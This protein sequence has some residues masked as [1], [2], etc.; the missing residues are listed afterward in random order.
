[1]TV[2]PVG[3]RHSVLVAGFSAYCPLR[4]DQPDRGEGAVGCWWSWVSWSSGI[5]L[6]WRFSRRVCR[7]LELPPVCRTPDL[8]W[9]LATGKDVRHARTFPPGVPAARGPARP[10]GHHMAAPCCA[11]R[12]NVRRV[13][14]LPPSSA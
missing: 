2:V 9:L 11:R 3:G 5:G 8:R 7:S 1:L 13:L 6:C 10:R 14:P 4:C 12:T